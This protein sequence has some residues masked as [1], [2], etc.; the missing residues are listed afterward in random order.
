MAANGVGK[1]VCGGF[2]AACH[3]LGR[4]PEWWQGRRWD[5]GVKL[6]AGSITNETQR[7]F[8][9]PVLLGD[10]LGENLGKGFIPKEAIAGKVKTRQ[11]GISDVADV[12]RIRHSSGKLSQVLFK[13]YEQGWRKWQGAAPDVIWGDEQPDEMA[14]NEKRIF[15]EMQTRVF[16]SSGIIFMTLTPLLGETDMIRHFTSA[17]ADG[18][19]WFGATWDDAPHL[20]EE[21]K[22]RLRAT[23]PSHELEVRTLG[24]P[25]MGEGRIFEASEESIKVSPF[26]IP[27]HFPRIKGVDFGVDHPAAVVELAIDRDKDIWYVTSAWRQSNVNIA[28]HAA[29]IN[30]GDRMVPVSWPHDGMNRKDVGSNRMPVQLWN[31]YRSDYHCNMLPM[32]ARYEK[33]KG[34]AQPQWPIIEEIKERQATG[35]FKVF[36]TCSEYFDEHRSYH[37][38]DGKIVAIRD[39]V[40]KATFYAAMMQRYAMTKFVP[41][42]RVSSGM[43]L[44]TAL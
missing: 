40:L 29:A 21:D 11:A 2:E 35:R 23:Y 16:R 26:E 25:M 22:A 39:D 6:W 15:A 41:R 43:G 28:T 37:L 10:D 34:G 18:I 9:Q 27:S 4:Y 8:T 30:A 24:V 12:V 44:S 31:I 32:S 38:K 20:A 7:E 13:T 14:A 5:R 19:T 17:K 36:S 1:T 33:D 42:R 3:L